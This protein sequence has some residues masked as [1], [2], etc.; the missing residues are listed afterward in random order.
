MQVEKVK[1]IIWANDMNR[2]VKFYKEMFDAEVVRQIEVMA[3]LKICD[4]VIGIHSGGEGKRTWTGMAFQV[5]DLF[6]GIDALK[7]AGGTLL[8]EPEDS[9]EDPAHIAMCLDTENNE[10]M[11]TCKRG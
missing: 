4:S 9:P 1:Y 2:A 3:E 5:A 7:A 6:A 10:I 8:K 11:L